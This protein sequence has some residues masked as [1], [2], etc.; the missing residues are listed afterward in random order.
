M[1]DDELKDDDAL[2]IP[3]ADDADEEEEEDDA[4]VIDDEE[5]ETF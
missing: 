1:I 2:E 5:E 4:P 3:L